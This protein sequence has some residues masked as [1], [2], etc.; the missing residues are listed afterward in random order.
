MLDVT[1]KRLIEDI[2]VRNNYTGLDVFFNKNVGTI[3]TTKAYPSDVNLTVYNRS[4][5]NNI[6]NY[7]WYV[8]SNVD[9]NGYWRIGYNETENFKK[10]GAHN[11]L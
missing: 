4:A 3:S 9:T 2:D 1:I 11:Q 8:R 7:K 6:I 10:E 5:L